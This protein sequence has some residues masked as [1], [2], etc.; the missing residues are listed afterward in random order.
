MRRTTTAAIAAAAVAAGTLSALVVTSTSVTAAAPPA[1]AAS[2][3]LPNRVQTIDAVAAAA[4]V[5]VKTYR[6]GSHERNALD[7]FASPKVAAAPSST[8]HPA[9]V[10]VHGGSWVKGDKSAMHNAAKAL[11]GEGYVAIPVN[12]RYASTAAW[13]AQRE[14]VQAAIRWVRSNAGKLHVDTG[15]IVVLGSSAGAEITASALTQGSGSKLARGMVVLSGPLD[16]E[17]IGRNSM[18]TSAGANLANIVTSQ[19]L[20]CLPATC[21]DDLLRKSSAAYRHDANDPPSLVVT[22]KSE[23]VDPEGSY[24]FHEAAR[25]D[26][27]ASQLKVLS[28]REHGMDYWDRA[29]PTIRTWIEKRMAAGR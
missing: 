11:V 9:V 20:R 16:L 13:P 26:G 28:G 2:P 6:Y 25:H 17:L 3:A 23:W 27:V 15:K 7:V 10:L 1:A 12:Y 19:L 5:S 22:S 14:D 29:W 4:S 18:G 24:R 8:R 21:T